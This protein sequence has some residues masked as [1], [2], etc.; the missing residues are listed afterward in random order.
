[1]MRRIR[2]GRTEEKVSAIGLG[3]WPF[4]GPKQVG[5]RAVGWSGHDDELARNALVTAWELG[6]NHWDTADVYGNGKAEAIIGSTWSQVPRNEI[7]LASKVGWDPGPYG[8]FYHPDQI[9]AQLERSL[10]ILKTDC[11]DLYYLHHCDFGPDDCYLDDSVASLRRFRDEGKIRF[12]GLSD[13]D[14]AKVERL[15]NRV[16]PD[17]VQVYRNIVDDSY[18]ES[19]LKSSVETR[20]LGAVFFS[21]L[22]H[23]LLLGKYRQPV[24]FDDGDMRGQ[25]AEFSDATVLARLADCRSQIEARFPDHS[26][27]VVRALIGAILEDSRGACTIVGQRSPA[28]AEAAAEAGEALGAK[29]ADWVRSLFRA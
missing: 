13:W 18:R 17:V 2:L 23:G 21:P 12:I 5:G 10:R 11:L 28:Q 20:D 15:I 14:N 1:M 6:V 25:I 3:T 9:L 26:Q 7:F 27:P 24:V 8:R 29:D 22:K 19:G 4:S 16:D